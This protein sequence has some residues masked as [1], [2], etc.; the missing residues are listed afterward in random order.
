MLIA[1]V[2]LHDKARACLA[3][4]VT[5][6]WIK[7]DLQN[8]SANAAARHLEILVIHRCEL[9]A[10]RAIVLGVEAVAIGQFP[11]ELLPLKEVQVLLHGR[12]DQFASIHVEFSDNALCAR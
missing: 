2:V 10:N 3:D 11:I 1:D 6:G 8:G 7:A 5:D 9:F 12:P 4:L